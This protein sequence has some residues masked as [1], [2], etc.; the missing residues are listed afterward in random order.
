MIDIDFNL[1]KIDEKKRKS[2]Y[3]ISVRELQYPSTD[4]TL[5]MINSAAT[6]KISELTK[7]LSLR[8]ITF[9]HIQEINLSLE[10]C[11]GVLRSESDSFGILKG[12]KPP[13]RIPSRKMIDDYGFIDHFIS[14]L[15]SDEHVIKIAVLAHI[16][17]TVLHFFRG[18]NGRTAHILL[19]LILIKGGYPLVIFKDVQ[20]YLEKI[21]ATN[22]FASTMDRFFI[23]ESK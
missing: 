5:K 10:D 18:G 6:Q 22:N 11:D 17:L 21:E 9:Q 1:K 3:E 8:E 12:D 20:E 2:Q 4:G 13:I 15:K 23:I 19:Q 16:R 14:G 7:S